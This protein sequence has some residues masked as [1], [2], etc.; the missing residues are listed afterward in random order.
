V[1]KAIG[2][3]GLESLRPDQAEEVLHYW[4][5]AHP[6]HP[7]ELWMLK[8]RLFGPPPPDQELL[9]AARGEEGELVGLA[10]AVYP[11]RKER[12]GDVRWLGALPGP[13][14]GTVLR[15]LL[16]E[17]SVRLT[18]RGAR[19]IHL[20]AT[21]P[22]YLRPGVDTR[23]TGLIAALQGMGWGHSATHFNMTC[24]LDAWSS[25]GERAIW[26]DV[27]GYRVRRAD[28][29]EQEALR[30]LIERE[31]TVAWFDAAML[32]LSHQPVGV[33]VAEK[34]D[35]LVGFAAYEVDQCLG[36]FGPTGVARAHRGH[37]LGARLLWACLD[38]LQKKRR[39]ECQIGWVGPVGFYHRAC[40]AVLGPAYWMMSRELTSEDR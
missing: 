25:P 16:D 3:V 1:A 37:G 18:A 13:Y 40:G 28:R 39:K 7:L 33:F 20:F 6:L 9:L 36:S 10:A 29:G 30:G 35:E 26:G 4:Q 34:G 19:E 27:S 15:Q 32:G 2:M 31:W 22:H 24:D 21:P 23:E 11:C 8:E 5:R 38:D 12:I 14:W 17:M